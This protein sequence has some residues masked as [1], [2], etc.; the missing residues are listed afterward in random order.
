MAY[1][2]GPWYVTPK[3]MPP[4]PECKF[5]KQEACLS[6]ISD[7]NPLLSVVGKCSVLEL[8]DYQTQRATQFAGK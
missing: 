3:E 1:F 8:K 4:Q 6:T 2:H 5:F 7:S